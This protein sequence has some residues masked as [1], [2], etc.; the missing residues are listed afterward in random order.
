MT[1][2]K[3]YSISLIISLHVYSQECSYN[4]YFIK[5]KQ[6]INNAPKI[7]EFF[8]FYCSY[9]YKFNII[10]NIPKT[11][12]KNIKKNI[13]T[14]FYHVDFLGILGKELTKAWIIA[15]ILKK[16]NEIASFIFKGIKEK[17]IK[18]EKD[19]K[20]IFIKIGIKKKTL[21][22]IKK[23]FIYQSIKNQQKYIMKKIKIKSVPLILINGKYIICNNL[24][25]KKEKKSKKYIK[26]IN[27]LIDN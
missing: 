23:S 22:S 17:K 1:K 2:T 24:I 7:I 5:I 20:K 14:T 12:E 8:S 26:I 9:C 3:L 25:I 27:F 4:D 13:K 19:I 16:E 10:E 18:N 11:I 6:K 15:T 21:N